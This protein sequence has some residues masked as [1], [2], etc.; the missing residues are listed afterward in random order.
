MVVREDRNEFS[1]ER[2][3]PYTAVTID[4]ILGFS[5][6]YIRKYI[7]TYIESSRAGTTSSYP[8]SSLES[9]LS[10]SLSLSIEYRFSLYEKP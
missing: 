3:K 1:G 9:S 4:H 5:R 6:W 7:L 8:L 10:L 2:N